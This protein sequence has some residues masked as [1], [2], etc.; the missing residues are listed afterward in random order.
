LGSLSKLKWAFLK[1][2][3]GKKKW[4]A[5]PTPLRENRGISKAKRPEKVY[6]LQKSRRCGKTGAVEWRVEEAHM[7]DNLGEA[8][9][10]SFSGGH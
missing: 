10:L 4:A 2:G 1:K 6:T 3:I 5:S 8:K 7:G 9:N